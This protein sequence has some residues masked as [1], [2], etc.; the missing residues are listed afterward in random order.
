MNPKT[1][2]EKTYLVA[3]VEEGRC[4]YINDTME[5]RKW[6]ENIDQLKLGKGRS[7]D[8]PSHLDPNGNGGRTIEF[9]IMGHKYTRTVQIDCCGTVPKIGFKTILRNVTPAY[10]KFCNDHGFFER[11]LK[12]YDK[13]FNKLNVNLSMRLQTFVRGIKLKTRADKEEERKELTSMLTLTIDQAIPIDAEEQLEDTFTT[14]GSNKLSDYLLFAKTAT[15]GVQK[16]RRK[17]SVSENVSS[18]GGFMIGNKNLLSSQSMS[19][20]SPDHPK[21]AEDGKLFGQDDD[22]DDDDNDDSDMDTAS[23]S[24]GGSYQEECFKTDLESLA[25]ANKLAVF[26]LA[27]YKV[28]NQGMDIEEIEVFRTRYQKWCKKNN[29]DSVNLDEE[30]LSEVGISVETKHFY[31]VYGLIVSERTIVDNADGY[32]IFV[33]LS[34]QVVIV[35]GQ[36]I[37]VIVPPIGLIAAV[38]GQQEIH[39]STMA[40]FP[41]LEFNDVQNAKGTNVAF[42]SLSKY[43]LT[44]VSEA[45]FYICVGYYFFSTSKLLIY[46]LFYKYD[47]TYIRTVLKCIF[48]LYL[49]LI[50]SMTISYVFLILR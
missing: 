25:P 12:R 4:T 34:M 41:V 47:K 9:I 37:L 31:D 24:S 27:Q 28:T 32:N 46:Y 33:S 23:Q 3:H 5:P 45:I 43:G 7:Y 30:S 10:S 36:L 29:F 18:E 6:E 11:D 50:L 40:M 1:N 15:V 13:K 21:V 26:I 14:G 17:L 16:F 48:Y 22:D 35:L 19:H 44:D 20:Q 2:K 49:V 39:R 42:E 8:I 38:L